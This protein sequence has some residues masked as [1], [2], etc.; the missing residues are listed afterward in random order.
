MMLAKNLS[1]KTKLFGG[2]SFLLFVMAAISA[3]SYFGVTEMKSS[4]RWV[5]HTYE[6]IRKAESV[7][8]NMVDMETGHRGFMITGLDEYLEPYEKGISSFKTNLQAGKQLTSDNPSQGGRWD[9]V[10]S[11]SEA[12]IAQV[13]EPEIALRREVTKGELAVNNFREISAR[14]V[15]KDIFDSIRAA[16]A[17]LDAQFAGNA[18]GRFLVLQATLDL[19]NMETGQRGFLLSGKEVSLEPYVAGQ[20]SLKNTLSE[21]RALAKATGVADNHIEA[22]DTRVQDWLKKAAEPEINARREMNKYAKTIEDIA[23]HIHEGDGKKLMDSIRVQIKE[24]VDAEELLIIERSN[25]QLE[26]SQFTT[27]FGVVGTLIALF[28]G[29]TIG[30]FITKGIVKPVFATNKIL[31]DIASGQ[32]D[33]TIRVPVEARDEIGQMGKNF[34]AFVNKLQGMIGSI[35]QATQKLTSSSESL[36]RLMATTRER[37]SDQKMETSVVATSIN[38]MATTVRDV[39]S[40]AEGAS[41]SAATADSEAQSGSQIV[42]RTAQSITMLANDIAASAD[43]VEKLKSDTNNIGTVLDVIKSIA[44]QTNLLALNAAIEAARAGEQ[45]RGFAVVADEVRT[46]AQ[47]TQDSTQE[48]ESLIAEL[49]NGAEQA[50]S[51]MNS[52]RDNASAVV[53]EAKDAEESLSKI[54]NAVA[55]IHQMNTQIATAAEEQSVVS[56]DIHRNVVSIQNVSEQTTDSADQASAASAMLAQL[57]DELSALVS[58]FKIR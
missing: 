37:L 42:V 10:L 45:G 52:S 55:G 11:L 35:A 4:S 38:Q 34:N 50:V 44:E 21:I 47:R 27:S 29:A 2:F 58:Q 30:W 32:G 33:L 20:A 22:V 41:Q 8:A 25:R 13:A 23:Q 15:G 43:A 49:Q 7:A 14:T 53:S 36:D 46:L 6:V 1:I 26:T 57:S 54:T 40:S 18:Q 5:N 3:V 51:V 19:V 39:A 56:E 9:R 17:S 12:W 16:L 48:I 24:I 28:F 31:E